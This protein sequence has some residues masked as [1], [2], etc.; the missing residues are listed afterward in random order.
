[1]TPNTRQHPPEYEN[2]GIHPWAP[3]TIPRHRQSIAEDNLPF[4]IPPP[5]TDCEA[6]SGPSHRGAGHAPSLPPPLQ[7]PSHSEHCQQRNASPPVPLDTHPLSSSGCYE[8]VKIC[9]LDKPGSIGTTEHM[10]IPPRKHHFPYVS[11]L[12]ITDK[13]ASGPYVN[14]RIIEESHIRA[15]SH[16]FEDFVTCVADG[17]AAGQPD[18]I[19]GTYEDLFIPKYLECEGSLDSSSDCHSAPTYTE[20][21]LRKSNSL[22][23]AGKRRSNT[24]PNNWKLNDA[25]T[26]VKLLPPRPLEIDFMTDFDES[27]Y[28]ATLDKKRQS[29]VVSD[30]T[31]DDRIIKPRQTKHKK[32]LGMIKRIHT[33]LSFSM[34]DLT[35]LNSNEVNYMNV[36]MC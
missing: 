14:W 31:A 12:N 27:S 28:R 4:R 8:N 36:L 23:D 3:L 24:I 29:E 1:M 32:F 9:P 20:V 11:Q 34:T 6:E 21:V 17:E 15:G 25:Y 35:R 5:I 10:N 30:T 33:R 13:R 16:L 22:K 26:E 19:K 2:V 18:P 7:P